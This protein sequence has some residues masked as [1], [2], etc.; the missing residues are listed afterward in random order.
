M[1]I[2][3]QLGAGLQVRKNAIDY[4]HKYVLTDIAVL[5]MYVQA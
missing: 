3:T 1:M 2:G 4:L 5:C